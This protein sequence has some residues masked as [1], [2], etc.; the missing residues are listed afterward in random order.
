M[1]DAK[2]ELSACGR[3]YNHGKGLEEDLRRKII[4]DIITK[5]GVFTTGSFVGNFCVI[6]KENRVKF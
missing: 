3:L 4:Q 2:A 6:A 5:G 1:F